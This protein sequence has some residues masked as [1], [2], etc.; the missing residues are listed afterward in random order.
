[1]RLERAT[2]CAHSHARG[3]Q[4]GD[5]E[6]EGG[7]DREHEF[8]FARGP[9]H[10]R[11]FDRQFGQPLDTGRDGVSQFLDRAG[12]GFVE[13]VGANGARVRPLQSCAALP[14]RERTG[15]A[16]GRCLCA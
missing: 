1:M 13:T 11:A 6:E 3:A 14:R 5:L 12:A 8:D 9:V 15:L 10:R 4:L 2:A 16:G 7:T